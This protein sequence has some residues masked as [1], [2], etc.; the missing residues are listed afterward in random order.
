M[1]LYIAMASLPT[2]NVFDA[3]CKHVKVELTYQLT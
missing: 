2:A 1:L 3:I